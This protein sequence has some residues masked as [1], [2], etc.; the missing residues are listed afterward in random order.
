MNQE[1]IDKLNTTL[2]IV[3]PLAEDREKIIAEMGETIWVE[4]L[5]KMMLA[6]PEEARKEAIASLNTDDLEKAVE[7]F[8]V[9]DVDID[10]IITEVSTSVMDEVMAQVS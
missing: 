8:S 5:G 7:I 6:L 4:S 3:S 9:H 2:Y 1:I 10:A